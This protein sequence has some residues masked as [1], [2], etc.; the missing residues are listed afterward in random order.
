MRVWVTRD[1]A[2]DG[3]LS[4]A[5]KKAGLTVV[6]EPVMQRR[7][8]HDVTDVIAQLG[9]DDWL[10]LT[11]VFAIEALAS[12]PAQGPRVAVVGE[13]SRM[14]AESRGFR[15]TL[16]SAGGDGKSLFRELKDKV[17]RGKVC[18][19]RSS[20]AKPPDPWPGLN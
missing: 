15:V 9:P 8:C 16:V 13:K 7:V 11:S 1:E 4:T 3:P 18:Y 20:L 2:P 17:T 19:P 12:A 14:V 10:V 5:L 6:W